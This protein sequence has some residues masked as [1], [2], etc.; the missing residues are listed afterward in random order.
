[1]LNTISWSPNSSNILELWK[2]IILY[3]LYSKSEALIFILQFSIYCLIIPNEILS[4]QFDNLIGK[5]TG[6]P[7]KF[8]DSEVISN[9]FEPISKSRKYIRFLE[10]A[11][12]KKH[13]SPSQIYNSF[14]LHILQFIL[15]ALC[16]YPLIFY[17]CTIS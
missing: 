6:C 4:S 2:T 17:I 3:R 12:N 1:M 9:L 5:I 16:L 10:S 8:S 15:K 7:G 13:F 11:Y 14:F